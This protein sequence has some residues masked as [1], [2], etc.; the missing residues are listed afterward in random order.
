[1]KERWLVIGTDERMKL[2]AKRL[3]NNERAVYYKKSDTW[4]ASLNKVVLEFNPT[5]I[6]LPIQPLKLEVEQLIG[7]RNAQIFAGKLTDEWLNLLAD[8]QVHLYL[9]NE[10]FIWKNAALTAESFLA[11]LYQEKVNV[12]HKKILITGFGRVGKMLALFLSRLHGKVII[13]VRSEAQKAEALCYGYEGIDLHEENVRK[14]D[15]IINTIPDRWLTEKFQSWMTCPIYDVAS[16]PGCLNE[17]VLSQYELLP[18]LP[19]KYFP[20]A[21]ATILYETM[22]ELGKD[23]KQ[24]LK[25]NA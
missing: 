7:I 15:Y 2:L 9:Q 19:G 16:A 23:E 21:A 5:K 10:V 17:I 22:L 18:A 14:V 25:E 3:S 4:D 20:Q 6:V 24:C 12:Q 11:H 13:A 1:M 8:E